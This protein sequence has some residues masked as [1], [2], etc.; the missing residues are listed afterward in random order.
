MKRLLVAALLAGAL[1]ASA[2]EINVEGLPRD[3]VPIF[4]MELDGSVTISSLLFP[5]LPAPLM[6]Y[7]CI[8]EFDSD[9][10]RCYIVNQDKATVATTDLKVPR[11]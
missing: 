8:R 6:T 5:K 11:K 7:M 3:L 4:N 10:I 2:E 9:S 1:A